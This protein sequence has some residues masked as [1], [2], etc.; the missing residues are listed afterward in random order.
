M[1]VLLLKDRIDET[2]S[3]SGNNQFR[4]RKSIFW[5]KQSTGINKA[6]KESILVATLYSITQEEHKHF[7]W[8]SLVQAA[9][10]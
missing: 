4:G 9:T 3:M 8:Y 7:S 5:D 2:I 6:T 10:I 1:F